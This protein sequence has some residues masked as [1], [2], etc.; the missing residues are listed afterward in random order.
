MLSSP[1]ACRLRP[2]RDLVAAPDYFAG[3]SEVVQRIEAT[4]D[5]ASL[6]ELLREATRL[7]GAD[8]ATFMSFIDD[9]EC[10]SFRY[11][12]AC[13]P[14]WCVDYEQRAWYADD[15]WLDYARR[16]AEPVRASEVAYSSLKQAGVVILAERYGFRSTAIV[17]AASSGGLSRLGMLCLGSNTSGFF[18]AEGFGSFKVAARPLAAALLEGCMRSTRDE[19]I[20]A[21]HINQ[22]E[23]VLLDLQRRGM[24]TKAI[25]ASLGVST[26]AVD[27]YFQRLNRKLGVLNRKE[28]ARL[29]AEYGLI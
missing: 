15:P 4:S 11:L 19:L 14:Q 22:K 10:E 2:L 29:A 13:D 16:H 5:A 20:R 18:E 3:V 25:A 21:W 26:H 1:T 27:S 28:A 23:L 17:P 8:V 6:F 7:V 24:S 9:G 12:L